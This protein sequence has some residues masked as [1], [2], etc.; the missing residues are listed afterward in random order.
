VEGRASDTVAVMPMTNAAMPMPPRDL[1][2]RVD[3]EALLLSWEDQSHD[4]LWM[5]YVVL[6]TR[7]GNRVDTL[8]RATN[9]LNDSLDA[10]GKPSTYRVLSSN[11]LGMR[12]APSPAVSAKAHVRAPACPS[13]VAANPLNGKVVLTWQPPVSEPVQ[14]FDVYR[15]TRG[16]EPV[17][18][19]SVS[20]NKPARF[21]DVSPARGALNFYFVRS[22]AASGAESGAS[23]EVGVQL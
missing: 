20:A 3:G 7:P 14:R 21:E 6:R 23:R 2:A 15:Y 17:K 16:S 22:V 12:S 10:S 19:G 1:T 13:A 4:P 9:F 11:A 8:L 5:G 18:V